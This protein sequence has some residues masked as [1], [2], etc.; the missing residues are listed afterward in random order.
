MGY[1]TLNEQQL[2]QLLDTLSKT[3]TSS[4]YDLLKMY[5]FISIAQCNTQQSEGIAITLQM[6]YVLV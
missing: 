5:L 2:Q 6:P 4:S 3:F 1:C